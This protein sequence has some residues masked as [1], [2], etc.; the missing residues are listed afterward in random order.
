MP[1]MRKTMPGPRLPASRPSRKMT[2]RLYSGT[3][4]TDEDRISSTMSRMPIQLPMSEN[5][6]ANSF[7]LMI[8]N[9]TPCPSKCV[10]SIA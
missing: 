7:T 9:N 3:I 4:L 1:G 8:M 2:S 6:D 5:R 10:K